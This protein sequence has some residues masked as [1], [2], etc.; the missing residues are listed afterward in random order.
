MCRT[1]DEREGSKKI[2]SFVRRL[3]GAPGV[4]C[5]EESVK[6]GSSGL[7]AILDFPANVL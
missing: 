5:A 7:P 3:F 4:Y 6:K 1:R 2:E